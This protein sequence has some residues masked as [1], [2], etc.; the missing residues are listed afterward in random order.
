VP[1]AAK[2]YLT[3]RELADLGRH[4]GIVRPARLARVLGAEVFEAGVHRGHAYTEAD[5]DAIVRNW[6]L[7]RDRV[8]V[9]LVVGHEEQQELLKNTGIPAVGWVERL[10][11]RGPKLYADFG[12]IPPSIA[13]LINARAYRTL[14]AEIYD[15]PPEGAPPG[16]RGRMA[17]RFAALGGELPQVKTLADLPW[18]EYA[19]GRTRPW[20][21]GPVTGVL[22]GGGVYQVFREAVPMADAAL[23]EAAV[24]AVK[25]AHPDLSDEF[26]QSLSDEQLAMLAT[27]AAPE[28][29]PPPGGAAPMQEGDCP[30]QEQMI[31]ELSSMGEDPTALAGMDPAA[32]CDLYRSKKGAPMSEPDDLDALAEPGQAPCPTCAGAGRGRA[33]KKVTRTEQFAEA[34]QVAALRREIAGLQRDVAEERRLRRQRA[35]EERH[36]LIRSFC[37]RMVK[38][39]RASPAETEH[40]KDG[41]PVGPLAKSLH[42]ADAVQKFSDGKTA[43]ALAME[44]VEARQPRKYGEQIADPVQQQGQ[45]QLSAERRQQLLALTPRGKSVLA[46]EEDQ[47]RAARVFA[48]ALGGVLGVKLNGRG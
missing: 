46:Q 36:G 2:P 34:R 45:R 28:E 19:E 7:A 32:L 47:T 48:E 1:A 22:A 26:L 3:Q 38:E 12:G 18:A 41:K 21:L 33:P 44:A 23:K 31:G 30:D 42:A 43:L 8:R 5:L 29:T 6:R 16:C 4:A 35:G 17:R 27:P 37:E 10:Y 11:R 20:A 24:A 14:S 40:G 9:P 13:R 15:E 25:A 39:G